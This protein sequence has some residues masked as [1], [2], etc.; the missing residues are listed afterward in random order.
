MT[1]VLAFV[2]SVLMAISSVPLSVI[3]SEIQDDS[4]LILL[5]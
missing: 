1:K 5:L 3:A 4:Y 2:L